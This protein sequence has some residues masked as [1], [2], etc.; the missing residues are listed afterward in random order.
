[1]S[2]RIRIYDNKGETF[3]RYTV[4]IENAEPEGRE[5][6][7][8]GMSNNPFS[9]QGFNQFVGERSTGAVSE[10]PHLGALIVD[11]PKDIFLAIF[12]RIGG[13]K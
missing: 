12:D 10:G 9:P 3:D 8:F 1:M 4:A 13:M 5:T 11:L 2:D 7:Y 6:Y